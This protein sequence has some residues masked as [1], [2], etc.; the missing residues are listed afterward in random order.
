MRLKTKLVIA[1]S[2]L[3][4][5]VASVLSLLYL[6]QLLEAT[7]NQSY[8]S[9]LLVAREVR[10]AL[11]QALE[12][13]LQNQVVHQ[14]DAAELRAM[15]AD[16]IQNNAGLLTMLNAVNRYSPT[17]YDINIGDSAD[18]I[19]LTTGATPEDMPLPMRPKI[20]SL[21]N[22]SVWTLLRV[23]MG[24]PQ[25]YDL[26]LP[27][28]RN[29]KPFVTVHVGVQTSLL[30]AQY[31]PWIQAAISLMGLALITA[32]VAALVLSNLALKPMETLSAR[33]D[34]WTRQEKSALGRGSE[35][36]L[37]QKG[38]TVALVTSKIEQIGHRMRTVEDVF[39][40]L[41]ENV[42]QVLGNLQDG[43]MLFAADGRAVLVSEAATRMLE[44]TQEDLLGR[45]ALEI[46]SGDDPLDMTICLAWSSGS[47]LTREEAIG[48]S[49][50]RFAVSLEFI[51]G[52]PSGRGLGALLTLHDPE[53]VEAIETE[54]EI[55][56]RLSAIGRLTAGVG[57]EVKN[58]INAIVVHLELLRNRVGAGQE[59]ALRHL[60]VIQSE[61]QRLDRVVQTLADFSRPVEIHLV[62]QDLR[63]IVDD[64]VLLT[65]EQYAQRGVQIVCEAAPRPVTAKV[66][67]DMIK[68]A[69][70][71]VALNGA[72]AMPEG[73]KLTISIYERDK[74]AVIHVRDEGVG[75]PQE[76]LGKIFD[77]YFTTKHEGSGI[78]LAMTYRILQ[79]HKGEV[80]VQSE[81]GRGTE[82]ELRIPLS[83]VD[84]GRQLALAPVVAE[85]QRAIG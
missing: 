51:Q 19:V 33:L 41:K 40:A 71:N 14:G 75:I 55:S 8:A 34:Y 9:N 48:M 68:Q 66:D 35:Q 74:T 58:P 67:G 63:K 45:T 1:I 16:A 38:D 32:L 10:Y 83:S 43:L 23:A 20:E 7:I 31:S 76:M 85:S 70:L 29:G 6:D 53:S 28:D 77:L 37:N 17:V 59:S 4:V 39:T 27:I 11:Q 81:V 18:H 79:L 15:T 80:H 49:G 56:R 44:R 54:L 42:N 3:V 61:I 25:V 52:G 12:A 24:P 69:V 36:K 65:K 72:Q 2:A 13:G 57:H 26:M 47:R 22:G 5:A 84:R 50:R 64:V 62:E 60:N 21:R 46:F 30:R 73:G 78:G 82:F